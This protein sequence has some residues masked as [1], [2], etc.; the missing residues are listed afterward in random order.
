MMSDD[1]AQRRTDKMP[2]LTRANYQTWMEK[3]KDYILAQ[4]H[5]DAIE[6]WTDFNWVNPNDG[7]PDPIARD[8]LKA[9]NNASAKKL[10]V[11]HNKTFSY[12]RQH[13][14]SDIFDTTRNMRTSV[15]VLLRHLR[16]QW[17]SDSS[18]DRNKL[19]K[20]Y[21]DMSLNNYPDMEAYVT[22][23]KNLCVVLTNYGINAAN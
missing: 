17:H 2:M 19:R 4:D 21:T 7:T 6:M 22:A 11:L 9:A 18:Y 8:W 12:L 14:S 5:D 10:R 15:P 3:A 16:D 20:E 1:D 13:L 23:F